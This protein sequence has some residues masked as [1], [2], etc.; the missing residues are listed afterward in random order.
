MAY[1]NVRVHLYTPLSASYQQIGEIARYAMSD[2]PIGNRDDEDRRFVDRLRA[3]VETM[4]GP[5]GKPYTPKEIAEGTGLT[6][7]YVRTL[8]RG[9]VGMPSGERVQRLAAFFGVDAS[10]FT[11]VEPAERRSEPDVDAALERAL[12]DPWVLQVA[13]RSVG[14]GRAQKEFLL[15]LIDAASHH[16]TDI[17][18]PAPQDE[19]KPDELKSR[20]HERRHDGDRRL[21]LTR[22]AFP[23]GE[24]ARKTDEETTE[25]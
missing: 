15:D 11:H 9:S 16:L 14:M 7:H 23:E 8:L 25:K 21:G 5:Q 18:R 1:I 2:R 13:R 24:R 4:P 3:L 22:D 12:S 19:R 6:Q 17:G 10:Y 20:E